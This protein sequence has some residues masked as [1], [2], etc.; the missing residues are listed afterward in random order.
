MVKKI[1]I[2]Y[3]NL[4]H[5]EKLSYRLSAARE[6]GNFADAMIRHNKFNNLYSLFPLRIGRMR[7]FILVVIIL[8]RSIDQYFIQLYITTYRQLAIFVSSKEIEHITVK[9]HRN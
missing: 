2:R 1:K 7:H 4:F 8:N 6:L 9:K 5:I 3:E